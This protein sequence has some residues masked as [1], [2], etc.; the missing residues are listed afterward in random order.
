M[1]HECSQVEAEHAS[2]V[3]LV[4]THRIE[5]QGS[6]YIRAHS[7]GAIFSASMENA[8]RIGLGLVECL[9]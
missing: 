5:G 3:S 4:A 7:N 9:V 2:E 8:S 1:D 6:K